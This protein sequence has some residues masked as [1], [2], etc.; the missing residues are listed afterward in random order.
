VIAL[1]VERLRGFDR[2]PPGGGIFGGVIQIR[3]C[4]L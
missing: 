3:G 1:R 2:M 4:N